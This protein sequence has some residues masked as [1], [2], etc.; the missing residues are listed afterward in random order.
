MRITL[1][2]LMAPCLL[3][4]QFERRILSINEFMAAP[5]SGQI[6]FIEFIYHGESEISLFD[7]KISD[8]RIGNTYKLPDVVLLPQDYLIVAS[9]SSLLDNVPEN[10][11]YVVPINGFPILNNSGDQHRRKTMGSSTDIR[12][13]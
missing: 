8:S 10:A 9:D 1:A 11:V 13:R 7:W 3:F 5:D 6:E 12:A 4:A 2:V